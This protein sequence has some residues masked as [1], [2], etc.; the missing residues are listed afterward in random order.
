MPSALRPSRHPATDT[1]SKKKSRW[2]R[3]AARS[4]CEKA[5]I[6]DVQEKR[7]NAKHA[8]KSRSLL[9]VFCVFSRPIAFLLLIQR[10]EPAHRL[11]DLLVRHVVAAV[12]EFGPFA[13]IPAPWPST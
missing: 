13:K 7:E 3:P 5:R 1:S 10:I 2:R 12:S 6:A 11:A 9:C 4:T 8:R